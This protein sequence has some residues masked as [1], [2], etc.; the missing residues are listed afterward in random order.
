MTAIAAANEC[1][2]QMVAEDIARG[3][4]PGHGSLLVRDQEGQIVHRIR[5]LEAEVLVRS[6][7]GKPHPL[8]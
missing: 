2:M 6:S 3:E 4:C 7:P 8:H 1:A 5:F